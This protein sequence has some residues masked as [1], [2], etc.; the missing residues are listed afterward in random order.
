M[1]TYGVKINIQINIY[2]IHL[3]T[4]RNWSHVRTNGTNEANSFEL[5]KILLMYKTLSIN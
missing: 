3:K 1:R 5:Y 2:T 4:K